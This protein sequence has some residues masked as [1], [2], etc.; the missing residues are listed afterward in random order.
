MSAAEDAPRPDRLR[1][2]LYLATFLRPYRGPF[3]LSMLGSSVAM[4]IG[5]MFPWLVGHLIDSALPSAKA[6]PGWHAGMDT[7]GLVLF[8]SLVVQAILTFFASYSFQTIGER[9]VVALRS[10]LFSRLLSLPMSIYGERRV[11]GL[12]SPLSADLT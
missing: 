6:E 11:G 8:G 9:A 1:E 12:S 2:L 5:A 7:I 4:G 10:R 3:L